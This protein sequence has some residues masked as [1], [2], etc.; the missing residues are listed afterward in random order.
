MQLHTFRFFQLCLLLCLCFSQSKN[1]SL[2]T[3]SQP[4]QNARAFLQVILLPQ[5]QYIF[6]Q[7]THFFIPLHLTVGQRKQVHLYCFWL[8]VQLEIVLL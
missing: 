4:L 1:L 5:D 7:M 2:P 3:H 8:A 6:Q